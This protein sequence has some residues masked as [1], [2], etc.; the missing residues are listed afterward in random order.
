MDY[1][2][3]MDNVLAEEIGK[4]RNFV[5]QDLKNSGM[6][7][8]VYSYWI[9]LESNLSGDL[10]HPANFIRDY[11]TIQNGG[12]VTPPENLA[13]DFI[14]FYSKIS[15]YQSKDIVVKN[16]CRYSSYYKKITSGSIPDE[17]IKEKIDEINS[18]SAKDAYPF[19][20]EVFEDYDYAHINK[21]MLLEILNTVIGF[22]VER[23]SNNPSKFALSFAGLSNEINKMMVLK[24]Y[25]PKFVVDDD[26]SSD[27]ATINK[28]SAI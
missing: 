9:E 16:L 10:Y 6:L 28:L 26:D 22:I 21:H 8:D 19:L 3:N 11:L 1:N 23:N 15:K 17:E 7:N 4:I 13:K 20:M 24:D 2:N 18:Y 5:F 25:I 12:L 27:C 14:I